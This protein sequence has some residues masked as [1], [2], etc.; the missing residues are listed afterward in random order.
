MVER[1]NFLIFVGNKKTNIM[2][3]VITTQEQFNGIL[4]YISDLYKDAY[5]F[6]NRSI[7]WSAM[8]WDEL[9]KWVNQLS[10]VIDE[11]NNFL[12]ME[13]ERGLQIV[14]SCGVDRATAERWI[15]V[16]ERYFMWGETYIE[17]DISDDILKTYNGK[18][19]YLQDKFVC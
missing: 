12:K 19:E 5:G 17:D 14:M 16:A 3:T 4:T 1:I 8:T 18:Y 13:E 7:N 6:R 15:K 9:A 11:E 10:E 2:N